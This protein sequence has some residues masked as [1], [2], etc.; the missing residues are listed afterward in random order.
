MDPDG[1][2]NGGTKGVEAVNEVLESPG[3]DSPSG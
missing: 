1:G 2:R 3:L